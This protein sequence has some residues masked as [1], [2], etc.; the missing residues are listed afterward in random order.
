M[1]RLLWRWCERVDEIPSSF[2]ALPPLRHMVEVAAI[3]PVLAFTA[4]V[5]PDWWERRRA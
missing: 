3:L 1:R 5:C 2:P 4:W